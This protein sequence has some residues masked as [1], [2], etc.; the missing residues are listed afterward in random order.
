[1]KKKC[2]ADVADLLEQLQ[3]AEE[4]LSYERRSAQQQVEQYHSRV[5]ELQ[6]SLEKTKGSM[7]EDLYKTKTEASNKEQRN[8]LLESDLPD[9]LSTKK[10]SL[11]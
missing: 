4:S 11:E 3:K 6:S 7:E 1:M 2:D 8:L 9:Y 5:V 10:L